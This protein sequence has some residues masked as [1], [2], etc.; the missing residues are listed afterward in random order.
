VLL[1]ILSGMAS[2]KTDDI[3]ST[4]RQL[5]SD[6]LKESIDN[7]YND[8]GSAVKEFG[9]AVSNNL[10]LKA[11]HTEMKR[12]ADETMRLNSVMSSTMSTLVEAINTMSEKIQYLSE[13]TESQTS[14][15][16]S[17]QSRMDSSLTPMSH[18]Q[19]TMRGQG[20]SKGNWYYNGMNIKARTAQCACLI[21]Q[22]IDI[23]KNKLEQRDIYYPDSVD[24]EF[25]V[26]DYCISSAIKLRC[27]IPSVNFKN[28][29]GLPDTSSPA[30]ARILPLIASS[31]PD[32]PCMLSESR[33]DEIQAPQTRELITH[34]ERIIQRLCKLDHILSPQ[35]IDILRSFRVPIIKDG[36]LNYD[37][38]V[39]KPR[40][41][42]T[43]ANVVSQLTPT[44]KKRYIEQI[45]KGESA[46]QAYTT[47]VEKTK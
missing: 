46:M 39:I 1:H 24:C 36:E 35:Q 23:I 29:I 25:T 47:A 45:I 40:S 44:E 34:I 18:K 15:I 8:P 21:S 20:A 12:N 4:L 22:F 31:S 26:L 14:A 9:G 3:T 27:M 33:L 16:V 32:E 41:S 11:I 38:S 10:L 19:T 7:S 13:L 2:K 6:A 42:H 43:L 37:I 28:P 30:Y 5:A 17:Q